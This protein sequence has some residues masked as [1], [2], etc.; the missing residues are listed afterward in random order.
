MSDTVAL[1]VPLLLIAM[2]QVMDPFF[3]KSVILLVHHDEEGSVGFILNR[4]TEITIADIMQGMDLRWGGTSDKVAHFGG[5]VQPQLGTV[6]Y[7]RDD[8]DAPLLEGSAEVVSGVAI[9]QHIGDLEQ[10]ATE[11]PHPLLLLLGYAG[12]GA[13]QLMEEILRNDWLTAPCNRD[14]IFGEPTTRWETALATVGVDP[15]SLPSWS[16]TVDGEEAN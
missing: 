8:P 12:W 10:L 2:P 11:P 16:P 6:L 4:Q 13:G 3:H 7:P 15:A 14:L 5:P 9:T 1:E